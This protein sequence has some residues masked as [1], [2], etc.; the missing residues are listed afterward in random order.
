VYWVDHGPLEDVNNKIKTIKRQ[1]YGYRFQ[2]F[3]KLTIM[4]AHNLKYGLVG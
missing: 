2:E 3:F 4:A 1:A